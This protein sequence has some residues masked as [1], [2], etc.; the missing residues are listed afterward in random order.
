MADVPRVECP[1]HVVAQAS[2]PWSEPGSRFTALFERVVIDWLKEA[3]FSAVV[4]RLGL[5]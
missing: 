5:T 3:S 1:E 4:W 2:T